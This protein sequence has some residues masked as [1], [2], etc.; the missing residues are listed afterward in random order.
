MKWPDDFS[1]KHRAVVNS[2]AIMAVLSSL[3][4]VGAAAVMIKTKGLTWFTGG[5]SLFLAVVAMFISAVGQ[6]ITM[7][8]KENLQEDLG[9]DSG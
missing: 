8:W 7:T 1:W 9:G 6:G 5:F 4:L 2:P 3:I